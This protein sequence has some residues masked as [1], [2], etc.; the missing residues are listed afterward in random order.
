MLDGRKSDLTQWEALYFSIVTITSLGYGDIYPTSVSTQFFATIESLFGMAIIGAFF[1]WLSHQFALTESQKRRN[2]YLDQQRARERTFIKKCLRKIL[3]F[4]DFFDTEPGRPSN[5]Y[6]WMFY[7][8]DNESIG[9][10]ELYFTPENFIR[11]RYGGSEPDLSVL[12]SMEN[13]QTE[14]ATQL[15]GLVVEF[16]PIITN[17]QFIEDMERLAAICVSTK[18]PIHTALVQKNGKEYYL[19]DAL[20]RASAVINQAILVRNK[21][22][23]TSDRSLDGVTHR[24]RYFYENPPAST[25]DNNAPSLITRLK[26]LASKLRLAK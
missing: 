11:Q 23:A 3:S 13:S 18:Y 6:G 22:T 12:E 5:S 14:L 7:D 10:N 9:V 17:D 25:Q 16:R 15:R 8:F 1:V 19:K 4:L 24:Y 20:R 2:E 21:L 26:E